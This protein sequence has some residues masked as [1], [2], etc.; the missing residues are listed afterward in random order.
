M[1]SA[2]SFYS[3]EM[4]MIARALKVMEAIEAFRLKYLSKM[5]R[6]TD[7]VSAESVAVIK[8]LIKHA[9][10][11]YDRGM[12]DG[13]RNTMRRGRIIYDDVND[14]AANAAQHSEYNQQAAYLNTGW[15]E[16]FGK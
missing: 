10:A 9:E 15:A 1:S 4:N 5:S 14:R 7:E 6:E 12:I 16:R 8:G 3:M 11:E 13:A 2:P